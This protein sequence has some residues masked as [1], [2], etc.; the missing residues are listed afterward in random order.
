MANPQLR[1]ILLS[2]RPYSSETLDRVEE[3]DNRL[4]RHKTVDALFKEVGISDDQIKL[5][6]SYGRNPVRYADLRSHD[7]DPDEALAIPLSMGTGPNEKILV[8]GAFLRYLFPDKR[9]IMIGGPEGV[10]R[11]PNGSL[12]RDQRKAVSKGDFSHVADPMNALFDDERI[13]KVSLEGYSLAGYVAT[14]SA[15]NGDYDLQTILIQDAVYGKRSRPELTKQF[16]KAGLHVTRYQAMTESPAYDEARD[17]MFSFIPY[18]IGVAR[19]TN[20]AKS[21]GMTEGDIGQRFR[22]VLH[23]HQDAT[24]TFLT[25]TNSEIGAN[26][27]EYQFGISLEQEFP[28][29]AIYTRSQGDYHA[30]GH[31]VQQRSANLT[32]ALAA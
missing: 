31:F 29:R 24:G 25:A 3:A 2:R 6:R 1:R 12:Y 11:Q 17:G 27:E 28:D 10:D 8:Y 21:W 16:L 30:F 18:I 14:Q 19:P 4:K 9:I 13:T 22:H 5:A 15:M 26:G 20:L 23:R 32:E 7:H